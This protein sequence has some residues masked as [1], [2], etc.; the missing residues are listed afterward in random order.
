[1]FCT[2]VIH[3]S[4]VYTRYHL[5]P[6]AARTRNIQRR[7]LF[8][9]PSRRQQLQYYM[10]PGKPPLQRTRDGGNYH[11][12]SSTYTKKSPTPPLD[13]K[14]RLANDIFRPSKAQQSLCYSYSLKRSDRKQCSIILPTAV[15]PNPQQR[16]PRRSTT[17]AAAPSHLP[18]TTTALSL[19]YSANGP[20]L[21][22]SAF[23]CPR[24][25]D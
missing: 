25:R 11:A 5:S 20:T 7:G 8:Y 1:M 24:Q 2:L 21:A 17:T 22:V 4:V 13:P 9:T 19:H 15:F 12:A 23:Q 10:I 16:M 3:S 14:T 18:F 6:Q